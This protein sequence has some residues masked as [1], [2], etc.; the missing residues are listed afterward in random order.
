MDPF[1]QYLFE[2]LAEQYSHSDL[3]PDDY[4]ELYTRMCNLD[5][6]PEVRPYLLTMRFFGWGTASERDAVLAE[7]KES[8]GADSEI[9]E[10]LYYD[11]LLYEDI[12]NRNALDQLE[13]MIEHGYTNIYTKERSFVPEIDCDD[14][15][16][17]SEDAFDEDFEEEEPDDVIVDH[18]TFECDPY[19]GST[20][21]AGDTDYLSAKVYIKP[22]SCKRHIKVRSQI[23][24]GDE[25]FS[26][27]FTNEYDIDP[28]T[29]WFRTDGWGN[30]KYTCYSGNTYRW[31]VEIDG[32][33]PYGQDFYMKSGKL[34]RAGAV[35]N[36][37]KTFASKASG[38]LEKD[39]SDYRSSFTGSTLEYVYFKFLI[40]SPGVH[41][42]VQVFLKITYLEDQS[43]FWDNYI[44]HHLDDD[45]VAFWTGVGYRTPGSWKKGLYQYTASVANGPKFEGMFT[46]S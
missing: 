16:P 43:I 20:F 3:S 19:K 17:E 9:L 35:V 40:D 46:V 5:H 6:L 7:L 14:E 27:V 44:I 11:L 4:E 28:G 30:T 18:I 33:D 38:A 32:G 36:D 31:L 21:T 26:K 39:R 10:G 12:T 8:L 45:T 34:D 29:R 37:V 22:V 15:E 42:N 24:L 1:D 41:K 2:E 13:Q 23:Y 25:A